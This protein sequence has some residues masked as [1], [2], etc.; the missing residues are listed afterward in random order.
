[1]TKDKILKKQEELVSVIIPT[2]NRTQTLERAIL[3]VLNQTYKN[4]EII[5]VDDNANFQKIRDNNRNLIKNLK[6]QNILFIENKIN[7]GGGPSRNEGIKKSKGKFIAFLDDDDEFLPN[8]IEKQMD[9]YKKLSND[10]VA[11]IY[12]YAK[13]INVDGTSYISKRNINGND[14]LEHVSNCIAATSW[15]FCSK[16]KLLNVGGF[17]NISSRQDASLILKLLLK[18]YEVHCVPEVLLKYYWHDSNSGISKTN[19]KSIEAEK[20]YREIFLENSQNL[21]R[22]TTDKI[23]FV[24][25]FR[26]AHLYILLGKRY[27]AFLELIKMVKINFFSLKNMRILFGILFNKTYCF[28]SKQKNKH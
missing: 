26:L 28:I 11:M 23:L 10:N 9:L 14:I 18:G 8:K 25:S 3:S 1:M 19:F 22:N 21:S 2:Y 24:F 13:M 20:K 12:C 27:F 6:C 5:I 7:L 4:I 15:W 16:E 17:E